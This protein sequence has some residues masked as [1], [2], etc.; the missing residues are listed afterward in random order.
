MK[1]ILIA[2]T[3]V[4]AFT[5]T[6]FAADAAT[7]ADDGPATAKTEKAGKKSEQKIKKTKKTKKAKSA[8]PA[9]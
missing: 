7:P 9:Q 6:G 2:L 1:K 8:A 4:L 5:A 3:M